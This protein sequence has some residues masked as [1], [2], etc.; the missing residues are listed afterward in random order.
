MEPKGSSHLCHLQQQPTS[1]CRAASSAS[2]CSCIELRNLCRGEGQGRQ[3]QDRGVRSP[4]LLW[5]AEERRV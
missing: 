4:C 1:C 5:K 2:S 3:G